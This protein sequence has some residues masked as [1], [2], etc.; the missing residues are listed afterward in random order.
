MQQP[1]RSR[2]RSRVRQEIQAASWRL[3]VDEGF[4]SVTTK[5][6]AEAAGVSE[7]TYFRY[8]GSKAELLLHPL[9]ASSAAIISRFAAQPGDADVATAL[10]AAITEV[11]DESAAG[12]DLDLWRAALASAPELHSRIVL[13]PDDDVRELIR[14]AH[15]RMGADADSLKP[16]VDVHAVLAGTAYAYQLWISVDDRDLGALIREATG[17]LVP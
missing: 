8:V 7:S 16:G 9:E 15:S 3:F 12:G 2:Q 14:L 11:T 13:V 10:A 5:Q 17:Y 4:A 6:I 1:L